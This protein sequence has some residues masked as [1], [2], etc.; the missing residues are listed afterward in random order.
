MLNYC[1][2]SQT[3]VQ[4]QLCVLNM[5]LVEAVR[6]FNLS[7]I[8]TLCLMK[9]LMKYK[10]HMFILMFHNTAVLIQQKII[11]LRLWH[12][13][14]FGILSPQRRAPRAALFQSNASPWRWFMIGHTERLCVAAL[15]CGSFRMRCIVAE[16]TPGRTAEVLVC[17]ELWAVSKGSWVF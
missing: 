6:R 1:L 16:I 5:L 14:C 15:S 12:L 17:L 7:W 4:N 3:D 10:K 9:T 13:A 2:V 8:H 11:K